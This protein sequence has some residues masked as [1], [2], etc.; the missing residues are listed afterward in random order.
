MGQLSYPVVAFFLIGR[1]IAQHPV[2]DPANENH[3]LVARRAIGKNRNWQ[4]DS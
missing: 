2:P 4:E 3:G 1:P